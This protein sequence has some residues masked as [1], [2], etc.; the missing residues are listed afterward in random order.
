[1]IVSHVHM[2]Q[3]VKKILLV[4]TGSIAA[5]KVPALI[6]ALYEKKYDIEIILTHSAQK[7][8]SQNVLWSLTG[9]KC[10]T[11]LFSNEDDPMLHITLAKSADIVLVYPA[12]AHFIANIAHGYAADLAQS[13]LL[14]TTA[15]IVIA[16]AMNPQMWSNSLTQRNIKLIKEYNFHI[17]DPQ[18]GRAACG[19]IGFGHVADPWNVANIV[20]SHFSGKRHDAPLQKAKILVTAGPTREYLDPIRYI[21]NNSS[22]RQGY[23]IAS[24]LAQAGAS[25]TL[26]SGPCHLIPPEHVNFYPCTTARDM[27]KLAMTHGPYDI[28][29]CT[30]AVCDYRPAHTSPHK[31]KKKNDRHPTKQLELVTNPDILKELGQL[32]EHKPKLLIGFAAETQNTH[33]NAIT[34]LENKRCHW[35][36][37]NNVSEENSPMGGS[38]N[39]VS[40]ITRETKENWPK[41]DKTEVALKLTKKIEA[42]WEKHIQA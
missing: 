3:H 38:I 33:E 9:K 10:H 22:G 27:H 36:V 31:I 29:I 35:I 41:M 17:I 18:Y 26:V 32:S 11:R 4:V 12:T 16:P 14:A 19:D 7:F 8:I 23:A 2:S 25:V 21:S 39:Q 20:S 5:I 6:K 42:W 30:A 40:L 24:C 37:A 13:V 28:A 15:P 34:K 1:M